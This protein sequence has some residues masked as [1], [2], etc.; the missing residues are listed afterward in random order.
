MKAVRILKVVLPLALA[1][2]G[3]LSGVTEA[4][5]TEVEVVKGKVVVQTGAGEVTVGAGRVA[6][7]SAGTMPRAGIAE[8]VVRDL[9]TL[10]SWLEADEAAEEEG[11]DAFAQVFQIESPS[12]VRA[13]VY[14]SGPVTP[15]KEPGTC[16]IGPTGLLPGLRVYDLQ[17]NLLEPLEIEETGREERGIRFGYVYLPL[18]EGMKPGE[19]LELVAVVDADL[20]T[21]GGFL[22]KDGEVW[23][24]MAPNDSNN[25]LS[26]CR[27]ILPPSAVAVGWN[28]PV[29]LVGSRDGRTVITVRNRY[30]TSLGALEIH[31]IWPDMD[32]EGPEEVPAKFLRTSAG[33]FAPYMWDEAVREVA[34]NDAGEEALALYRRFVAEGVDHSS[35]WFT[36]GLKLVG[37]GFYEEAADAFAR[38]EKLAGESRTGF[39]A[40]VWQGHMLD[41]KGKRNEA[42]EKYRAAL[43]MEDYGFVRHDQWGIEINR[44]WTEQR[45]VVPFTSSL[46]GK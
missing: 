37:G 16:R 12:Q 35:L 3:L 9:L 44:E 39:A 15:G 34:W 5:E 7:L 18:P 2:I 32:G 41:L 45:L 22:G 19:D 21:F 25:S 23:R 8:P 24:F 30:H 46:I 43:A 14:A 6:V 42:L 26:Y 29:E 38:S 27:I 31:F 20:A 13:A 1:A 40:L 11:V 28:Q 36:L 4:G 17:G 33:Y 10:M